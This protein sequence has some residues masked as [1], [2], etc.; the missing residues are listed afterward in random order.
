MEPSP[1][2]ARALINQ[3]IISRFEIIA[4]KV[5]VSIARDARACAERWVEEHAGHQ[6]GL[7]AGEYMHGCLWM[8][9]H[10]IDH[11]RHFVF[12]P[13]SD[14]NAFGFGQYFV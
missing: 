8:P 6:A 9:L 7:A 2:W 13:P 3:D 11:T 14:V 12:H 4:G 1:T 10:Q 5:F